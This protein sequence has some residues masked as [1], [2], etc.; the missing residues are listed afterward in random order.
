MLS[1]KSPR[2]EAARREEE[3]QEEKE[4]EASNE[5]Q[6]LASAVGSGTE[7]HKPTKV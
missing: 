1:I 4:A 2:M 5:M 6:S 3:D 7:K